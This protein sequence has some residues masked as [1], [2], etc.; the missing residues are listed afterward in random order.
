MTPIKCPAC[1]ETRRI[2]RYEDGE[3]N[4]AY[5]GLWFDSDDEPREERDEE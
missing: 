3:C 4:C 2:Y 5:C 1:G